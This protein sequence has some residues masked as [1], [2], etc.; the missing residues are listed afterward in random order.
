[1]KCFFILCIHFFLCFKGSTRMNTA[2]ASQSV[3]RRQTKI[4][5]RW[6]PFSANTLTLPASSCKR[7][8]W[9]DGWGRLKYLEEQGKVAEVISHAS[10]TAVLNYHKQMLA[11][12]LIRNA[13]QSPWQSNP[14]NG[15]SVDGKS[16]TPPL[17]WSS[18]RQ[19]PACPEG[20]HS[21]AYTPHCKSPWK[22]EQWFSTR[23]GFYS[24]PVI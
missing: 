21:Q 4:L 14:L 13:I 5:S 6:I 18:Q 20:K 11:A 16:F 12:W 3:Q 9:Q 2:P 10:I 23:V 22:L 19:L 24:L 7:L 8:M 17:L 15:N 1:M